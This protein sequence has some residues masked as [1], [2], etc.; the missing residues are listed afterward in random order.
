MGSARYGIGVFGPRLNKKGNSV[1]GEAIMKYLSDNLLLH[2]FN[3]N[4]NLLGT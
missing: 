1:G 3:E 2:T 4:P